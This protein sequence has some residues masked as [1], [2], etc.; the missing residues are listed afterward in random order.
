MV[1]EG[2]LLVAYASALVLSIAFTAVAS[3]LAGVRRSRLFL[4]LAGAGLALSLLLASVPGPSLGFSLDA[5]IGA[6]ALV[7]AVAGGGPAATEVLAR[8]TRGSVEDGPHGGILLRSGAEDEVLRG[9][10]AIGY[11][12][13]L[14]VAG[15]LLAGF[16]EGLAI[17]VAIKGVGRFTEL[18]SAETRERFIIGT[19][20]SLTW[21]VAATGVALLARG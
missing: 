12:E 5:L 1:A 2:L 7:T 17:I 21:A 20:V 6:A 14:A 18:D 16:P 3:V 10:T 13:R 19:L 9:G 4:Y 15:T 11:L 8:A